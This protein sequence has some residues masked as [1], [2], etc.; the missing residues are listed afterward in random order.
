MSTRSERFADTAA[1][2]VTL[3][4]CGITAAIT[5]GGSTSEYAALEASAR[6]LMVGAP[7][8]VGLYA[9]GLPAFHRFGN[10]LVGAGIGWFLAS[11]SAS[12]EE[13]LHSIGRISGW[14]VEVGLVY[15]VLA[16]PSGSLERV[17]KALVSALGLVVVLLY[18]PTALLVEHYPSPSPWSACGHDCPGNAFMATDAEPALV[19]DLI[20]PVRET[21][22][23]AIFSAATVRLGLRIQHASHITRRALG[24]VL[25]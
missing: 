15:L 6:G 19:E 7:I 12:D 2:A 17:D 16:F 11:F 22:T 5:I 18:L 1:I 3:A 8:A 20:R 10:L 24:P 21:L 13:L 25:T 23:V 14:L 4:L 9:R